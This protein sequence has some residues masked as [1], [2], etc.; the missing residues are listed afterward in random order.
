MTPEMILATIKSV[1]DAMSALFQFLQTPQGQQA[2]QKSF[3]DREKA[4]KLFHDLGVWFTKLF[5]GQL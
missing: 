2:L 1:A 4:E 5:K 3:E